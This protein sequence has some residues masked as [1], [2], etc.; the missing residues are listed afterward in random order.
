[1]LSV[2]IIVY[3]VTLTLQFIRKKITL[4]HVKSDGKLVQFNNIQKALVQVEQNMWFGSIPRK[5]G[6]MIAFLDDIR[7]TPHTY[8]HCTLHITMTA[9]SLH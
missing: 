3:G 1:M 4:S 9:Y 8:G 2:R 7:A 6:W 5:D